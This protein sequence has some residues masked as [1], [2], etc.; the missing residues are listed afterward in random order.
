MRK[1]G[2][3][4]AAFIATSALANAKEIGVVA[5]LNPSIDGTP[6]G[7]ATRPLAVGV[8]VIANERIVSTANG[9]GQLLFEDQTTLTIAP[10][11]ELVLD[12]FV[13]DPNQDTGEIALTLGKGALRFIGG[14]ITKKTDAVIRTPTATIGVRGGIILAE[15]LAKGVR[16]IFLAGEYV[17]LEGGTGRHCASRTGAILTEDG[18]QGLIGPEDLEDLLRRLDGEDLPDPTQNRFRA[19]AAT[20]GPF[21][22]GSLSTSGEERDEDVVEDDIR[23]SIFNDRTIGMGAMASP[24]APTTPPNTP[25]P[26]PGP[27]PIPTPVLPPPT[28]Q[29]TTPPTTPGVIIVRPATPGQCTSEC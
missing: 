5:S 3:L 1:F 15:L 28:V 21:E 26:N 13:Y 27:T 10:N 8:D 4:V 14:R 9:R 24:M 16:V 23:E 25:N 2:C 11:S 18:Y 20:I 7:Q 19:G 17:C 6:P 29:P 12:S 22:K